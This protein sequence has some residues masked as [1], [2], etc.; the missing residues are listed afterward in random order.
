MGVA[1][2]LRM[3]PSGATST[4]TAISMTR[5]SGTTFAVGNGAG[6]SA[7]GRLQF[8]NPEQ[9]DYMP[10]MFDVAYYRADN[11]GVRVSGTGRYE[12]AGAITAI[13]FLASSGNILAGRFSLYGYRKA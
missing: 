1:L 6:E 13:R 9:T 3:I 5:A 12:A 11:G 4:A 8:N 10:M 7:S 2:G